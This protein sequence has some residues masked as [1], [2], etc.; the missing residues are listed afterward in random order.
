M[1]K[2]WIVLDLDGTLFVSK[3]NKPNNPFL[4]N[5]ITFK[6]FDNYRNETLWIV[7]RPHL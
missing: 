2:K 3:R 5:Q 1:E 4:I 7:H 6:S